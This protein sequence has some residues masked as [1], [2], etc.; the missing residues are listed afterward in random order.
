MWGQRALTA[1][2]VV[3]VSQLPLEGSPSKRS[4]RYAPE[5]SLKYQLIVTQHIWSLW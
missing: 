1:S 5:I 2:L 3:W 4:V